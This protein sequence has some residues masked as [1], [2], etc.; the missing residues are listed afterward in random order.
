MITGTVIRQEGQQVVVK[1]RN[2]FKQVHP[3]RVQL[4]EK[5]IGSNVNNDLI[6]ECN[7]NDDESRDNLDKSSDE[8]LKKNA[9]ANNN[10]KYFNNECDYRDLESSIFTD[11]E[12]QSIKA[13]SIL[14]LQNDQNSMLK[15]AS[16]PER[17]YLIVRK[18]PKLKQ[19][20]RYDL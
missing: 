8:I 17:R 5:G 16:T 13:G 2:I 4:C 12:E 19:A 15:G 6:K 1:H 9:K 14:T 20:V 11:N 10:T 7:K 3:C 18:K